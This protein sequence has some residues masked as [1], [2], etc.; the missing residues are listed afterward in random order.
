MR[1]LQDPTDIHR[2]VTRFYGVVRDDADLGPIFASRIAPDEWPAHLDTMTRFWSSVVLG[3]PGYQGNPLAA[4]L[5]LPVEARHFMRWLELW[6]QATTELF[7]GPR[8][9]D[10]VARA[11]RIASVLSQRLLAA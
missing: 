10:I 9:E 4:H 3:M 1:D 2:L 6:Q 8:A 5:G 11:R 7:A